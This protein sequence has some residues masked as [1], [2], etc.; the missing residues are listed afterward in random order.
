MTFYLSPFFCIN[1]PVLCAMDIMT[2][3]FA[4][5]YI[6]AQY[7]LKNYR[8]K[9]TMKK[10]YDCFPR[11]LCVSEHVSRGIHSCIY[12]FLKLLKTVSPCVGMPPTGFIVTII[13]FILPSTFRNWFIKFNLPLELCRLFVLFKNFVYRVKECTNLL[14]IITKE[15]L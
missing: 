10:I 8:T 4:F 11:A 14:S 1:I 12:C 2:Y 7:N 15:K 3:S 5:S 13:S 6:K 9:V